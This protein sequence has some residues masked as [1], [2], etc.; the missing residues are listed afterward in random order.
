MK[1]E[2]DATRTSR[3]SGLAS[4]LTWAVLLLLPG[5]QARPAMSGTGEWTSGGPEG[6]TVDSIAYDPTTPGRVLSGV[7]LNG[8][9]ES[10]DGGA[11]WS[12]AR[13]G[14][15]LRTSFIAV[16]PSGWIYAA[17]SCCSS[18]EVYRSTDGGTSW[19]DVS[20]AGAT[21]SGAVAVDPGDASTA[22]V[23]DFFGG[24]YKTVDGGASWVL[25]NSGFAAGTVRAVAVDP[26]DSLTVYAGGSG[27]T[28]LHKSLDGGDTWCSRSFSNS[29]GEIS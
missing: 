6:G 2:S 27:S 4:T 18:E 8:V 28:N 19:Q 20:I 14:L 24:V 23:G 10:T 17:A 25:K 15:S 7:A 12:A 5:L 21:V 22:Y 13:D 29:T 16:H 11:T 9:Y 3:R 1:N 26:L